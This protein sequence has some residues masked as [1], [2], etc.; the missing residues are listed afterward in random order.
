MIRTEMS[1]TQLI[2]I[3]IALYSNYQFF[4]WLF[5]VGKIV[6]LSDC[7]NSFIRSLTPKSVIQKRIRLEKIQ[8]IKE[9]RQKEK[10]HQDAQVEVI[11]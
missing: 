9:K 6:A 7:M 1:G 3:A 8:R 2:Y 11:S 4:K 5:G 10:D